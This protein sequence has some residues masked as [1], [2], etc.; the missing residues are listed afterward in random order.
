M[1]SSHYT[2]ITRYIWSDAKRQSNLRKHGLD[3]ADAV[4]VIERDSFTTEDIRFQYAERRF[5][6]LGYF[7]GEPVSVTYT[8]E[9]DVIRI[10][11]FRKASRREEVVLLRES[12]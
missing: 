10:I 9:N 12:R 8:E 1:S 2:E 5:N 7:Q 4:D 3:F 6:T 11:S